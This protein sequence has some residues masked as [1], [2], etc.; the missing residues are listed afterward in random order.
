M[1]QST[2]SE[3]TRTES[4]SGEFSALQQACAHEFN[5][6]GVLS[7]VLQSRRGTEHLVRPL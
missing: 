6:R 3:T 5:A 4:L 2:A 1:S 7:G